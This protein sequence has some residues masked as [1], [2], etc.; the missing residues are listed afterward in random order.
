MESDN[1]QPISTTKP[2][3]IWS[4]VGFLIWTIYYFYSFKKPI[5]PID[6]QPNSNH[7]NSLI[8]FLVLLTLQICIGWTVIA[9]TPGCNI[10]KDNGKILGKIFISVIFPWLFIFGF[11]VLAVALKPNF[12]SAFSN[13][14]GYLIVS[15]S[16]NDIL[17]DLLQDPK[18][19][20]STDTTISDALNK[21]YGNKGILINQITTENFNEYIEM[22]NPLLKLEF[23]TNQQYDYTKASF[24]NTDGTLNITDTLDPNYPDTMR[25]ANLFAKL[26]SIVNQRD[27]IGE[28]SWYFYTA[29]FVISIATYNIATINCRQ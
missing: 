2:Y 26:Y 19:N 25:P 12:K 29:L 3:F 10:V 20:S 1:N 24:L 8:Y 23:Q 21:I 4:I 16:A 28:F 11:S 18:A 22:L 27:N 5:S 14:Y 15:S 13:I 7:I 6:P 17:T 9:A